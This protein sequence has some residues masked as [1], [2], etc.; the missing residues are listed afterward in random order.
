MILA[1]YFIHPA[2]MPIAALMG[3]GIGWF[4][5]EAFGV[6]ARFCS[7]MRPA[8][9]RDGLFRIVSGVK[10]NFK[11]QE[12][13]LWPFAF[14]GSLLVYIAGC[15]LWAIF[16][17][18]VVETRNGCL[19]ATRW[20]CKRRNRGKCVVA[21]A[22]A[23]YAAVTIFWGLYY[24]SYF[25]QLA[26][27]NLDNQGLAF[28]IS[29]WGALQNI[30]VL[31]VMIFPP[32]IVLSG[33]NERNGKAAFKAFLR[34]YRGKGV[35]GTFFTM[36]LK[37]FGV[38][39][40]TSGFWFGFWIALVLLSAYLILVPAAVGAMVFL[41]VC[42]EHLIYRSGGKLCFIV[43]LATG[44]ASWLLAGQFATGPLAAAVLALATGIAAAVLTETIRR[45]AE[46]VWKRFRIRER[47]PDWDT[48]SGLF[49]TTLRFSYAQAVSLDDRVA[50]TWFMRPF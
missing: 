45:A 42:A 40:I 1:A 21:A 30:F 2:S 3:V 4:H 32:V 12:G 48:C 47:R 23:C 24:I 31:V 49:R 22:V 10:R 20:L 11:L 14:A 9:A 50:E 16:V 46:C 35:L 39:M 27:R 44:T 28:A 37:L 6:S 18:P 15:V 5:R 36:L 29:V 19:A 13:I 17:M 38:T 43:T 25:A 41:A 34:S 26:V 8:A 33:G 7:R